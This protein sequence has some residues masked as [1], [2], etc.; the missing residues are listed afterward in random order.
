MGWGASVWGGGKAPCTHLVWFRGVTSVGSGTRALRSPS[1]GSTA[2][3]AHE[4][5]SGPVALMVLLLGQGTKERVAGLRQVVVMQCT[6]E[7]TAQHSAQRASRSD[8]APTGCGKDTHW[9]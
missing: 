1:W 5:V 2:V 9:P 3:A 4:G 6:P 8:R 7:H